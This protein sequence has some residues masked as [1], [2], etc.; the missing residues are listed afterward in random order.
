[1]N[2]LNKAFPL[3]LHNWFFTKV[4]WPYHQHHNK[5]NKGDGISVSSTN[6]AYNKSFNNAYNDLPTMAP[7]SEPMPP[8]T[9]A[10]K[11]FIPMENAIPVST[12]P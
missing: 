2:F 8:R 1:M 11:V 3:N 9:A 4:R 12:A 6:I 10:A 5:Y 7:G